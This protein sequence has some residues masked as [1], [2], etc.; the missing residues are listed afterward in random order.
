MRL[1]LMLLPAAVVLPC[2]PLWAATVELQLQVLPHHLP[3]PRRK[4]RGP[5]RVRSFLP[6]IRGTRI[7]RRPWW[8]RIPLT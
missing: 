1:S 6:T 4:A 5:S 2:L 3:L 8:T 7:S